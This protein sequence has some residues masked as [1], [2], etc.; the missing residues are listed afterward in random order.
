MFKVIIFFKDDV[1]KESSQQKQKLK[2]LKKEYDEIESKF[3]SK[4]IDDLANFYY[5]TNEDKDEANRRKL[6]KSRSINV[7]IQEDGSVRTSKIIKS[8]KTDKS[9]KTKENQEDED[10][11]NSLS[12]SISITINQSKSSKSSKQ[13]ESSK[14]GSSSLHKTRNGNKISEANSRIKSLSL[15]SNNKNDQILL[16]SQNS[17]EENDD[18][19]NSIENLSINGDKDSSMKL[20]ENENSDIKQENKKLRLK[21]KKYKTMKQTMMTM[22]Q[23]LE[24]CRGEIRT[25]TAELSHTTNEN[26]RLKQVMQSE[27]EE[28]KVRRQDSIHEQPVRDIQTKNQDV[29]VTMPEKQESNEMT[30]FEV[31]YF[32]EVIIDEL[33]KE[34]RELKNT[35]E[36]KEKVIQSTLNLEEQK[37]MDNPVT[38][39][40]SQENDTAMEKTFK[41]KENNLIQ[42][43]KEMKHEM[44]VLKEN[45]LESNNE[46]SNGSEIEKLKIEVDNLK[47]QLAQG[48]E[49]NQTLESYI[50]LLKQSYTSVFGPIE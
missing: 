16:E 26:I 15:K 27:R 4:I 5:K 37:E 25:V 9:L 7:E 40:K 14:K 50:C 18:T 29:Q 35:A 3:K 38:K 48:Q 6:I 8:R 28:R 12:K 10:F 17:S 45:A 20:L 33:K 47:R 41:G 42:K 2:D 24:R 1:K 44:E 34:I 46:N 36:Q 49:T 30:T 32:T 21:F 11:D 31:D 23:E 39:P 13:D 43:I 19:L 22:N